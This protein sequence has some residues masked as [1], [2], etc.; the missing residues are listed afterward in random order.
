M[1]G[2]AKHLRQMTEMAVAPPCDN[3]TA[4]ASPSGRA[5]GGLRLL[6]LRLRFQCEKSLGNHGPKNARGVSGRDLSV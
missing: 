3:W 4:T 5:F 1:R 2:R 6:S